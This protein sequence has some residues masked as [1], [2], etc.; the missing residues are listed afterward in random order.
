M[1]DPRDT[2]VTWVSPALRHLVDWLEAQ[3]AEDRGRLAWS[4]DVTRA[5]VA[6]YEAGV[7]DALGRNTR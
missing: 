7:E 1:S 6:A 3:P 5:W 4:D 2:T